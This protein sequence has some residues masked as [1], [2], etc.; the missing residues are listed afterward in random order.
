[1]ARYVGS[2]QTVK[3][4]TVGHEAT[5]TVH[6]VNVDPVVGAPAPVAADQP[7]VAI[8]RRIPIS[9]RYDPLR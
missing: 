3:V 7:V 4:T 9:R 5:I 1:M 8:P 2:Q 6:F